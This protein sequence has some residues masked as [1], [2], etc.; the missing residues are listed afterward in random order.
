MTR[1]RI[2]PLPA[3]E[4]SD[5]MWE[6][7]GAIGIQKPVPD[8]PQGPSSNILG[9]YANHPALVSGWMQFSRHLKN[10]TLTDRVREIAIIRT[11]WL[12]GGEYEWAQHRRMGL[13]AG[14]T[15]AE[16]AALSGGAA[17]EWS[18]QEAVIVRAIDE[19]CRNRNLFD[20]TWA[21]LAEFFTKPQLIDF[22]FMVSTYDM[23][24]VAFNTLGL[25]LDDGLQGFPDSHPKGGFGS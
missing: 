21:Q 8:A 7:L 23:H 20:D 19:I 4:W 5:Q 15:E 22:V 3:E 11:T 12:G 2:T 6:A 14:L 10:S 18:E 13:A 17:V 9:I 24:C 1:T 16:V 25:Q